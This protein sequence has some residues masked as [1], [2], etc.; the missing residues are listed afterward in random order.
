MKVSNLPPKEKQALI[1][2]L[3]QVKPYGK[4]G[5][6]SLTSYTKWEIAQKKLKKLLE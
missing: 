4:S 1:E 6:I 2:Q 3:K 5:N